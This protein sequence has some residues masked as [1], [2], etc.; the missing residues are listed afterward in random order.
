MN[1]KNKVS[2]GIND[3]DKQEF[4]TV[5]DGYFKDLPQII[6]SKAVD[7]EKSRTWGVLTPVLKFAIP[8]I[9]IL[10][11]AYFGIQSNSENIDESSFI[12]D[13]TTEEVLD[14]LVQTDIS[15]TDIV[16]AALDEGELESFFELPTSEEEYIYEETILADIEWIEENLNSEEDI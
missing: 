7:S 4:Y 2:K 1:K 12:G 8:A 15:S 10:T 11:I 5:P 16:I 3:I 6:Q 13:V 14:Y 9:L